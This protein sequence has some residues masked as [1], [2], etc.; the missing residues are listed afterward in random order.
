[1]GIVGEL[2]RFRFLELVMPKDWLIVAT[3]PLRSVSNLVAVVVLFAVSPEY[4]VPS[5]LLTGWVVAAPSVAKGVNPGSPKPRDM[6]FRNSK[7]PLNAC[8]PCVQLTSSP[9]T[10]IGLLWERH[11]PKRPY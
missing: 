2:T 5:R 4:F 3:E 9:I 11:A 7:P 8:L 1:Y 10:Y 6:V